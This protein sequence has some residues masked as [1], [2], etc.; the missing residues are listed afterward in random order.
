MTELLPLDPDQL[1]TTT[2][3]VRK[4]LDFDRPVPDSVLR[5]C[6]EVAIQ[7]PSGSN[8]Q[9]W[10]WVVVTDA[11]RKA[12]LAEIYR[13]AFVV[14][15]QMGEAAF[16]GKA[17][18]DAAA[19]TRERVSDS[20][21]YLADNLHRVP[22][23]VVPCLWGRLDEAPSFVAASMW[24]SLF[25]AVWSFMLAAR[26]RGL[27]TSWTSLH[28]MHEQEAA[29]VLGI[30]FTRVAQGALVPVAYTVGTDFAPA[31]RK[32]LDTIVHWNQW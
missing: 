2:R 31:G 5:E 11:A 3:S 21:A 1:L 17:I 13:R 10:H 8:L 18:D 22:A 4:R 20:A 12:E 15:R 16:A 23:I 32:D 29:E 25:P 19:R 26:A 14:Y 9:S 6:L 24:A 27:G 30:P 7:A 28:L